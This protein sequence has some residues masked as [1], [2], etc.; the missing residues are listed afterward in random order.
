MKK[1]KINE[2]ESLLNEF[3]ALNG[4]GRTTLIDDGEDFCSIKT[5]KLETPFGRMLMES[6]FKDNLTT[7]RK[8]MADD[9]ENNNK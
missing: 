4:K 7:I 2:L 1:K 8:Q 5:S 9:S 3:R 6:Y